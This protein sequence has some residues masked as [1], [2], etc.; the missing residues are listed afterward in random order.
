MSKSCLNV[1]SLGKNFGSK[2]AL[3]GITMDVKEGEIIGLVGPNGAGKTTLIKLIMGLLKPDTG[4]VSLYGKDIKAVGHDEM[5]R[6][7][8][9]PDEPFF[10][11]FMTARQTI[12]FN[13]RFYPGWDSQKCDDLL[14]RFHLPLDEPVKNMSRGMKAQLGLILVLAQKADFLVLDEP[15][16]GLDPLRRLEFLNLVLEDFLE[17]AGRS[18]LISSHYLEELER[19]VDRVALLHEGRLL[20]VM[21]IEQLKME[22]KTIRVVF[23]K[24]PPETL[25]NM[26]GIKSVQQE[27]KTSYL[28]TMEDNFN[29]IYEACSRYP[30]FILEIYHRNLEDVFMDFSGRD[31][32][33]HK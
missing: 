11:D 31:N 2:N 10:Y 20:K 5:R 3:T 29:A 32:D 28:L 23:Q 21:D 1:R 18:V 22:E 7:G 8:Y 26:S 13:G 14:Q 12:E 4:S 25:L 24:E 17:S 6:V 27:G 9:I 30:H 33:D 15:L 16:E 19:V